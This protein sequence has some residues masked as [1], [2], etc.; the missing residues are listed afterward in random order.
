MGIDRTVINKIA[1]PALSREMTG[2]YGDAVLSRLKSFCD[3]FFRGRDHQDIDVLCSSME[4]QLDRSAD[5]S[6]KLPN[7]RISV[8]EF[9]RCYPFSREQR[10]EIY[11]MMGRGRFDPDGENSAGIYVDIDHAARFVIP[12]AKHTVIALFSPRHYHLRRICAVITFYDPAYS[13]LLI[14]RYGRSQDLYAD[15]VRE[16]KDTVLIQGD[17]IYGDDSG[18]GLMKNRKILW[19][20]YFDKSEEH[21]VY[22]GQ[23][24]CDCGGSLLKTLPIFRMK[25]TN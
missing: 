5:L 10:D 19:Y 3:F 11:K 12:V 1:N 16:L 14:R 23:L 18:L 6:L 9:M 7:G 13:E 17:R 4:A 22:M 20:N 15:T 21:F 8:E 2:T 24:E 25:C